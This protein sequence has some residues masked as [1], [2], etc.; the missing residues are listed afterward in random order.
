LYRVSV[1]FCD[2]K[3]VR[4]IEISGLS[5][6]NAAGDFRRESGM[7]LDHHRSNFGNCSDGGPQITILIR[8]VICGLA[9]YNAGPRGTRWRPADTHPRPLTRQRGCDWSIFRFAKNA[10]LGERTDS[11]YRS[12]PAHAATRTW[13][14]YFC[15]SDK[16]NIYGPWPCP[17]LVWA[18]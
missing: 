12:A 17:A 7:G 10:A 5:T 4:H 1:V 16:N 11:G 18:V 6:G 14:V 15:P 8:I 13:L 9:D 3:I 2:L